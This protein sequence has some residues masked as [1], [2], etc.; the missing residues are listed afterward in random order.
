MV[1]SLY[2]GK[3]ALCRHRG[4]ILLAHA[5]AQLLFLLLLL[6]LVS[7]NYLFTYVFNIL[8]DMLSTR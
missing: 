6:F 4:V 1:V 5:A 8:L 2:L 7:F 3:R